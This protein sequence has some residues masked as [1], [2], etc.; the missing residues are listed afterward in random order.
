MIYFNNNSWTFQGTACEEMRGLHKG[1][2]ER[3]HD[4]VSQGQG[5]RLPHRVSRYV[6]RA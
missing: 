5:R 2:E 4:G 6:L 3:V 1:E